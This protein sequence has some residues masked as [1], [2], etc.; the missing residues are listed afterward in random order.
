MELREIF[1]EVPDFRVKGRTDH[2]LSE[3]LVI[4][5]C[6]VISGAY[7]LEEIAEYGSQKEGFLRGF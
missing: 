2:I 3:I 5:L 1:A 7:D 4:S 6:A